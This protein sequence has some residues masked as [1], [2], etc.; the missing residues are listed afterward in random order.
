MTWGGAGFH[1]ANG[2]KVS[3]NATLVPLPPYS[4]ELNGIENP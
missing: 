2:L 4:P 3:A 1:R